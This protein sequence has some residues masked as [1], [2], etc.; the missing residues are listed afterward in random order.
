MFVRVCA[1]SLCGSVCVKFALFVC[2]AYLPALRAIIIRWWW[3]RCVKPL[4][5]KAGKDALHAWP[6]A[7]APHNSQ[8]T[9]SQRHL[10]TGYSACIIN[11]HADQQQIPARQLNTWCNQPPPSLQLT[12]V[13]QLKKKILHTFHPIIHTAWGTCRRKHSFYNQITL[14][15]QKSA[16]KTP[17]D[18]QATGL[19]PLL[20][21]L[22]S[23]A[24]PAE[25]SLAV[26]S[27]SPAAVCPV[28]RASSSCQ[29]APPSSSMNSTKPL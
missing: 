19:P 13:G 24:A 26:R 1:A 9:V 21:L 12:G 25:N 15:V 23:V 16:A 18:P 3:L 20:L 6:A 29:P 11:A 17:T 8:L 2:T 10:A 14:L 4:Q 28:M 5:Q 7:A 22:P 27:S